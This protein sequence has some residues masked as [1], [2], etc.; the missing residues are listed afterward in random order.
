MYICYTFTLDMGVI[1]A[2]LIPISNSY[3]NINYCYHIERGRVAGILWPRSNSIN[4]SS[5]I[6]SGRLDGHTWP[7]STTS[8]ITWGRADGLLIHMSTNFMTSTIT[9]GRVDGLKRP[10][11]MTFLTQRHFNT[12]FFRNFIVVVTTRGGI[13]DGLTRQ[14]Y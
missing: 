6:T 4:I 14:R 1:V 7:T 10:M 5:A 8:V 2:G 12:F 9:R 13:M 3:F 11:Y